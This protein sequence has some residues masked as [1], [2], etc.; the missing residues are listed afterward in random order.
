MR[1]LPREEK[2]FH[3]LLG[4]AD[5]IRE[6]SGALLAALRDGN[7]HLDDAAEK[8]RGFEQRGDEIIHEVFKALNL[9][10][11]T[12]LD[13]EDLHSL[14]SHLDDVLDAIEDVSQRLVD[15]RID[16]VT[17]PMVEMAACIV[18]CSQSLQKAFDALDK[19][20]KLLVHCI[21][22]NRLEE[23]VDGILR[24]AIKDLFATEQDPIRVIKYKEVYEFL[25]LAADR[26][27]DVA[28]ALQNVVIKNS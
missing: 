4:Q 1:L 28:D 8:I 19:D 24:R 18:S 5:L 22:I 17:P 6:A 27:E 26:C 3:Y 20:E 10:F 23:E 12:P 2:F 7:S 15:Y 14:A 16:P 9:T 11:I 25:E 21:E 13:P